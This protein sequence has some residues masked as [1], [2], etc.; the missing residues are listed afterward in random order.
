MDVLGN[1]KHACGIHMVKAGG[2]APVCNIIDQAIQMQK[3]APRR[4]SV[5]TRAQMYTG[6]RTLRIADGPDEVHH[7]VLGSMNSR[8]HD[9]PV[10][11]PSPHWFRHC[12]IERP[13]SKQS[14]RF[15]VFPSPPTSIVIPSH[16][17][18]HRAPAGFA[19]RRC[20][21]IFSGG[22]EEQRG[23]RS[24]NPLTLY[25]RRKCCIAYPGDHSERIL[26]TPESASLIRVAIR[27]PRYLVNRECPRLHGTS[28]K[29]LIVDFGDRS[30]VIRS[31]ATPSRAII[32]FTTRPCAMAGC[33]GLLRSQSSRRDHPT[34]AQSR[35][36]APRV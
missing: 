10:V 28:L 1:R 4:V 5:D 19:V 21:P 13:P 18:T 2:P 12:L 22:A 30:T 24:Y 32:L 23:V 29:S 31:S 33:E 14:V 15:L 34:I 8:H 36:Q 26:S 35:A 25:P 11:L 20:S 3:N 17:G 6:T 7:M 16:P 27:S 9:I